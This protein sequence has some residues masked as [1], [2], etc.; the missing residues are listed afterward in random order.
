[1]AVTLPR[2]NVELTIHE[3]TWNDEALEVLRKEPGKPGLFV[4]AALKTETEKAV[5]KWT[6]D[7]KPG[8]V[9]NTVVSRTCYCAGCM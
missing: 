5:W 9:V 8:F 6:K 7:T 4:Y 3:T 1:M 2:T